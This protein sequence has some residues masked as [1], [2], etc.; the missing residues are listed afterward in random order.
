MPYF[1]CSLSFSIRKSVSSSLALILSPSIINECVRSCLA[2]FNSLDSLFIFHIFGGLPILFTLLSFAIKVWFW[3]CNLFCF[4]WSFLVS[5]L[6]DSRISSC[7]FCISNS[8][9]SALQLNVISICPFSLLFSPSSQ[10]AAKL[11]ELKLW[12]SLFHSGAIK[13]LFQLEFP[14]SSVTFLVMLLMSILF[15]LWYILFAIWNYLNDRSWDGFRDS[16]KSIWIWLRS[17]NY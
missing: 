10:S 1:C 13:E 9:L 6:W 14:C 8:A 11:G 16:W 12:P 17:L 3:I 7:V 5:S 15:S 4:C 2:V